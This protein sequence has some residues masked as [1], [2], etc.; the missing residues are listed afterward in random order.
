MLDEQNMRFNAEFMHMDAQVLADLKRHTFVSSAAWK[1]KELRWM[2]GMD[3]EKVSQG[4][5]CCQRDLMIIM[6]YLSIYLSKIVINP[7]MTVYL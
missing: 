7:L 1:I 3:G 4:N 6:N 5:W 2:I